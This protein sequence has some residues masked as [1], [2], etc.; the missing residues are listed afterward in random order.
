MKKVLVTGENGYIGKKFKQWIQLV[1]KE[2]ELNYIS[3]RG[4]EWR[5]ADFSAY[6]T[7]LHL[8]GIAHVSRNPKLKELYYQ[9]NR[10]LTIEL[11]EKAKKEN[12]KQFIFMSSIIVYGLDNR[13]GDYSSINNNTIP[14]PA[15]FYGDSKLQADLQIQSM[16]SKEF[17][18]AV[19]RT[20][21]VYGPECKGNFKKIIKLAKIT[22]V[23]IDLN[24]KRSMI[25]IDNLNC[26]I[27][28]IIINKSSGVFYPQNT[29]YVSTKQIIEVA[30]RYNGRKIYFTSSFNFLIRLASKKINIINKI[31]GN[32]IYNKNLSKS[33]E[34]QVCDFETSIQK[35]IVNS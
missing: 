7:V 8:A 1:N 11:A 21:I 16:N 30:A 2:I 31:F 9:I 26:L 20:P 3:V 23:F 18:T 27:E 34:Y 15:D 35:S 4:E 13:I 32:K 25:Y 10:D 24:N 17:K 14:T 29:E 22:P 28:Q 33:N 5:K 19:I 12:I 6:D